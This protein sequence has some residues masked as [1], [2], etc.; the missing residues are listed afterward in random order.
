MLDPKRNLR[1]IKEEIGEDLGNKF[2]YHVASNLSLPD[3]EIK[4]LGYDELGTHPEQSL[5]ILIVK[6]ATTR[7]RIRRG[8]H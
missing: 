8:N 1:Y 7:V 3:E 5:S 4:E 2:S 6:K